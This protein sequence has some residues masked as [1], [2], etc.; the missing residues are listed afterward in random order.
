MATLTNEKCMD[1]VRAG[2][3]I[4]PTIIYIMINYACLGCGLC[5]DSGVAYPGQYSA[6]RRSFIKKL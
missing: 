5:T 6:L 3:D 2:G 4:Q 1:G